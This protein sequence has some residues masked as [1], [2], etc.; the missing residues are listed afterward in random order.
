MQTNLDLPTLTENDVLRIWASVSIGQP[1][2]CWEWT[3]CRRGGYGRIRIQTGGG[4]GKTY[5]VTRL[6]YFLTHGID[7]GS[8][9][10]LHECDNPPCCNP[11]HLWAGTVTDNIHD[12]EMKGRSR[13]PNGEVV[14]TAKMLESDILTIRHSTDTNVALAKRFG[15]TDVAISAIRRGQT[16]KHVGGP[17]GPRPQGRPVGSHS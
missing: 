15:I 9:Q 2:E 7:P 3:G 13:H 10:I 16:W 12:M 14:N 5:T 6:I 8:L 4:K 11:K 1:K 17:V